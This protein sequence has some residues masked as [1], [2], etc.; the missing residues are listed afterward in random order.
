MK[1]LANSQLV[2]GNVIMLIKSSPG[3]Q[4]AILDPTA[5]IPL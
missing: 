2:N 5:T 4:V 3:Q 1:K